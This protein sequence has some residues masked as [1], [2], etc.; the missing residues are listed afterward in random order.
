MVCV[1]GLGQG[2]KRLSSCWSPPSARAS[3]S[4]G[5]VRDSAGRY[6]DAYNHDVG[7]FA[8][9][10]PAFEQCLPLVA[11]IRQRLG[12][13]RR[14]WSRQGRPTSPRA[15]VFTVDMMFAI[16]QTPGHHAGMLQRPGNQVTMT[17]GRWLARTWVR[18]LACCKFEETGPFV[19]TSLLGSAELLLECIHLGWTVISGMQG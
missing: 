1:L 19:W 3:T 4:S 2:P 8:S 11:A 13:W 18:M 14:R 16:T 10:L 15:S 17:D 9:R 5:T 6:W 12:L 7:C